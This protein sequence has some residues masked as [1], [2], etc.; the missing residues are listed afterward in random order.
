M[1]NLSNVIKISA[2]DY[3]TLVGGGTI[4][5]GGVT[6]SYDANAIYLVEDAVVG[7]TKY[8]HNFYIQSGTSFIA[9]F[10]IITNS[11]TP[12]TTIA[13]LRTALHNNGFTSNSSL[14]PAQGQYYTSGFTRLIIGVYSDSSTNLGF[15]YITIASTSSS[16]TMTVF[17]AVS[18]SYTTTTTTPATIYDIVETI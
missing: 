1:A 6:Y 9:T 16:G 11:A 5:K 12:I 4:T 14:C 10:S 2:A 13:D 18:S 7:S 17:Q 3:A 8:R 15:K